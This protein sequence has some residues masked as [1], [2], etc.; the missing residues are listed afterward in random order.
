MYNEVRPLAEAQLI[1]VTCYNYG[2]VETRAAVD[3]DALSWTLVRST[4]SHRLHNRFRS[5]QSEGHQ[6][7]NKTEIER[8]HAG[9]DSLQLLSE[10]QMGF[11]T[12]ETPAQKK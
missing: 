9:W 5:A 4:D 3:N 2:D 1:S 11:H 8:N 6:E 7:L 10:L 12:P